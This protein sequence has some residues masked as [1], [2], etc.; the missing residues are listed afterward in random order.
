MPKPE[1]LFFDVK[2][3]K[4]LNNNQLV[5]CKCP[6]WSDE[7]FQIAFWNGSEFEYSGQPNDMF[8]EYVVSFVP[9]DEHTGLPKKLVINSMSR[10]G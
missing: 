6:E 5:L 1:D 10:W 9:L 4:V 8:N 3:A 7:G 2:H